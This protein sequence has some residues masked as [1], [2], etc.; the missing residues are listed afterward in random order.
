[1]D[2]EQ[3]I[4]ELK[5]ELHRLDNAILALDG[6]SPSSVNG[7]PKPKT[8]H[9]ITPEGRK[10]LSLM[11]KKRWAERRK[12]AAGT[13]ASGRKTAKR[14]LPG[15]KNRL[16][17]AGRRRLSLMMKRR[18]AQGKM[19]SSG[20]PMSQPG[21]HI[22]KAGRNKIAAAQRARWAKLK[23]DQAKKNTA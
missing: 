6:G 5:S 11:M 8:T 14:Q 20:K 15:R 16:T 3:I 10:R 17:P 22:S 2:R 9:G 7:L 12:G 23:S 21:R 13:V 4:A 1:V 19:K 18:W